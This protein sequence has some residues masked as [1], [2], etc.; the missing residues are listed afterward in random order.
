MLLLG[1]LPLWVCIQIGTQPA[2]LLCYCPSQR[3]H[4]RVF[5]LFVG[6]PLLIQVPRQVPVHDRLRGRLIATIGSVGNALGPKDEH[7]MP[8]P[9]Q[10]TSSEV[11]SMATAI[12]LFQET[13]R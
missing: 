5:L 12:R 11:M 13:E 7:K 1:E 6:T 10:R 9:A 4:W 2:D 8:M 3:S